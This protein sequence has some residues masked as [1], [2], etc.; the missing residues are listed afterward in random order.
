MHFLAD[1]DKLVLT[2]QKSGSDGGKLWEIEASAEWYAKNV[3]ETP[4]GVCE[5]GKTL[6]D[7]DIVTVRFDK[8]T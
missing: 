1:I 8:G 4:G 3:R 6:K 7:N 2:L 5:C